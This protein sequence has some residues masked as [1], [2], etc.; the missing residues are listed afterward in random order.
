[1]DNNTK[2]L[3]GACFVLVAALGV[4]IGFLL[5][6]FFQEP[7]N[8]NVV[9]NQT[10]TQNVSNVTDQQSSKISK[11]V[12][13]KAETK[14]DSKYIT[15]KCLRCGKYFKVLRNGPQENYCVD[16]ENS[17]EVQKMIEEEYN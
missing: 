12:T 4:I 16:C 1:M 2:I 13:N 14:A 3:L 11:N 9:S 15:K 17:P 8:I 6:T 7:D 5:P 10:V